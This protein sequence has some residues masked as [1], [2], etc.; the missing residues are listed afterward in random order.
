MP[1]KKE[2][3]MDEL[4]NDILEKENEELKKRIELLEKAVE[5]KDKKIEYLQA[6]I[7]MMAEQMEELMTHTSGYMGQLEETLGDL[8]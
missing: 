6:M 4:E 3:G 8:L 1:M 5:I 2:I 7:N